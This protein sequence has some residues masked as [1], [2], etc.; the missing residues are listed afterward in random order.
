MPNDI[1]TIWWAY[2]HGWKF[3]GMPDGLSQDAV[4]E[5]VDKATK[6]FEF[7]VLTARTAK[8]PDRPVGIVYATTNGYHTNPVVVW[9]DWA[10]PRNKVEA[11]VAY[12]NTE[13]R[14][15]FLSFHATNPPDKRLAVHMC[16]YGIM[17]KVGMV[18][19]WVQAD[20]G[21]KATLFHSRRP[22]G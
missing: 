1:A 13:R 12:I 19:A 11:M 6:F 4:I 15:R 22:R 21:R 10:T 16:K 17:R 5:T 3:L 2:S 20:P 8:G 7:L 9:F 14:Q 18:H